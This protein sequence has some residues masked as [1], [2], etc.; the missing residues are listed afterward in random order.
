MS[1]SLTLLQLGEW[2]KVG[3]SKGFDD[4]IKALNYINSDVFY[5]IGYVLLLLV[6]VRKKYFKDKMRI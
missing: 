5:P 6:V 2:I 3:T 1:N 4:T